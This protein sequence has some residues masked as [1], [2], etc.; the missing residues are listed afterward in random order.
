MVNREWK[1]IRAYALSADET[2]ALPKSNLVVRY[3]DWD[4]ESVL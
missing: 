3:V 4:E 1:P 2:C